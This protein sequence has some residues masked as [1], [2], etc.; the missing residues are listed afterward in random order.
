V[1]FISLAHA[2]PCAVTGLALVHI[3]KSFATSECPLRLLH[4][5]KRNSIAQIETP[6]GV[7][8]YSTKRVIIYKLSKDVEMLVSGI[9]FG[10]ITKQRI[11]S[12]FLERVYPR[13][14]LSPTT[15]W[16]ISSSLSEEIQNELATKF[17]VQSKPLQPNSFFLANPPTIRIDGLHFQSAGRSKREI[18]SKSPSSRRRLLWAAS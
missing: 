6:F 16:Q 12:Q 15:G 4:I 3:V 5:D 9:P 14:S 13:N 17:V 2:L 1:V 8:P 10:V 7:V 18:V 11:E